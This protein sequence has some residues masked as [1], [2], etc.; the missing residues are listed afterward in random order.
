MSSSPKDIRWLARRDPKTLAS[1]T[2]G[3][4]QYKDTKNNNRQ[5]A[6]LL[7]MGQLALVGTVGGFVDMGVKP[8]DVIFFTDSS[9]FQA[10]PGALLRQLAREGKL[11]YGSRILT[12]EVVALGIA[13]EL[14]AASASQPFMQDAIT[15]NL[16]APTR[17]LMGMEYTGTLPANS[18]IRLKL[19]NGTILTKATAITASQ[20]YTER[21]DSKGGVLMFILQEAA[22]GTMNCC[23]TIRQPT[24]LPTFW[25]STRCPRA[26]SR[27]KTCGGGNTAG[28]TV[29]AAML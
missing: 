1:V 7:A 6:G 17:L 26:V 25:N 11:G 5:S 12:I 28:V 13:D 24:I 4:G 10:V 2:V 15:H 27:L 3:F 16:V 18:A 8:V 19:P 22:V 20:S 23:S 14:S 21:E 29:V 9:R